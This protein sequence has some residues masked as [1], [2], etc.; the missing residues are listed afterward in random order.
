MLVKG[1]QLSNAKLELGQTR[2]PPLLG[3]S[4]V[5]LKRTS[6]MPRK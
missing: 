3:S 6:Y 1:I 2:A 5:I 4:S